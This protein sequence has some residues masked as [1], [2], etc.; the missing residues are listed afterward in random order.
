MN[1]GMANSPDAVVLQFQPDTWEARWRR[2][3]AWSAELALVQSAKARVLA[4]PLIAILDKPK[5][6]PK[7][8]EF[9]EDLG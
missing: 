5:E 7:R 6:R 8:A 3:A 9:L 2:I 4:H 1:E